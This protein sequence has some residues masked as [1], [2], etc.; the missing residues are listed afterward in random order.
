[1][2]KNTLMTIEEKLAYEAGRED[3]IEFV[4]RLA[5]EHEERVGDPYVYTSI[6]QLLDENSE[7][8][9]MHEFTKA[10]DYLGIGEP[11]KFK[12]ENLA[13]IVERQAY[14]LAL[15]KHGSTRTAAEEEYHDWVKRGRK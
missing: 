11:A 15:T 14:I 2:D 5:R 6:Q 7:T 3:G 10:L 9:Y 1:M 12:L 8:D 13:L 4:V